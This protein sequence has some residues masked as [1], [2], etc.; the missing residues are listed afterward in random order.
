[1]IQRIQTIYLLLAAACEGLLL[2]L[3]IY[4]SQTIGI[5]TSYVY[6]RDQL[7]PEIVDVIIII[8]CLVTIFFYKNRIQ[9]IR[10]CLIII[11]ISV[12]LL[13]LVAAT[14]YMNKKALPDGNF[15]LSCFLPVISIIC[16]FMAFRHI[17]K[18][19]ALVKSMDRM[20]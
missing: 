2:Y 7:M 1:M 18:D 17:R 9:Q 13:V 16:T 14:I 4:K 15:Q 8:F 19:E 12:L 10:N 6:L 5:V 11:A 3:P 20:R